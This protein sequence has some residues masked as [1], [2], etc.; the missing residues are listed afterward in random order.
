VSNYNF[1]LPDGTDLQASEVY[2]FEK[3]CARAQLCS[4]DI[5]DTRASIA[6]PE[7]MEQRIRAE[8]EGKPGVV[9][10]DVI[11]GDD[12]LDKGMNLIHAVGRSARHGA[13]CIVI[14]YEGDSSRSGEVDLAIVGKGVTYDTGGLNIKLQLIEA[15][16]ADKGGSSSVIGAMNACIDAQV[17]K[18][19]CFV[20]AIAEN[21]IGPDSYKPG[22]IITAM[23]GLTVEIGNTDAEGRLVMCDSMT[24]VQRTY[25]PAKVMYIATLTGA[26]IRGLG[27]NTAGFF[28]PG[29]EMATA[30]KKASEQAFENF[31]QL[32][33]G[34]DHREVMKGQHGAD[35]NNLGSNPM[36]AGGASTAAAYLER[37]IEN[38][39]PWAHLDIACAS[40]ND[41][42][43][44]FGAKTLLHLIN[45]L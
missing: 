10:I 21:A 42:F 3:S 30:V 33:I 41:K 34:D 12:L 6:H 4:E 29:D 11:K 39:R 45:N 7:W 25:N 36:F 35:L 31:W 9:K 18:N 20:C 22:D 43:I 8:A 24:Y 2:R 13:R 15:M 38:D 37:F 17:K 26:V 32:P 14:H 5:W 27:L 16:H 40:I 19:V 28:A 1:V 44:G 23:N